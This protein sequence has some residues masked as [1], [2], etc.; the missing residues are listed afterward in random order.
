MG[1]VRRNPVINGFEVKV[2]EKG[3]TQLWVVRHRKKRTRHFCR[4][5]PIEGSSVPVRP[6]CSRGRK[7][8][9]LNRYDVLGPLYEFGPSLHDIDHAEDFCQSCKKE[10]RA[11]H[12]LDLTGPIFTHCGPELYHGQPVDQRFMLFGSTNRERG[13]GAAAL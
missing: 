1:M 12:G 3:L 6:L 4:V 9:Y 8:Q 11:L 5:A 7:P 13:S 2:A 10:F